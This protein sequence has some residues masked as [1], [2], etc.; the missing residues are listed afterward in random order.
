MSLQ[1]KILIKFPFYFTSLSDV[2]LDQAI[3][4]Q[5]ASNH[6]AVQIEQCECRTIHNGSSCQDPG[7]GYYRLRP[8]S[9]DDI[10]QFEQF[11]G[12]V[13][14]CD[15][16]GR[17]DICDKET[18]Q[19]LNC[20]NNTG[21]DRCNECAEG[22]YG[23]PNVNGCVPC[24][25]PETRKNFAKGCFMIGNE[26]NCLCKPGYTG[27]KC[28]FCSDGFYGNP[29][30][31]DGKCDPCDCNDDG[32]IAKDCDKKTGQCR[33]QMGVSG[34]K[35]DRCDEKKHILQNSRC[36][37]CD[38]CSLDLLNRLD[39][40]S[41]EGESSIAFINS[42][43]IIAPW[44]TLDNYTQELK[45]LEKFNYENH[46]IH[47]EIYG[48]D[49]VALEKF[50]SKAENLNSKMK[51]LIATKIEKRKLD[52]E[53][54]LTDALNT[55]NDIIAMKNEINGTIQH[56]NEYGSHISHMSVQNALKEAQKYAKEIQEH[57]SNLVKQK[58]NLLNA[59]M[60]IDDI[61]ENVDDLK[62]RQSNQS[63]QL[64]TQLKSLDDVKS[65]LSDIQTHLDT[66]KFQTKS[67]QELNAINEQKLNHLT[68]E[69]QKIHQL[70]LEINDHINT[71]LN[72]K[73]NQL[74]DEIESDLQFDDYIIDLKTL[75]GTVSEKLANDY[76]DIEKLK[77]GICD[78]AE[79]W[80]DKLIERS[81]KYSNKFRKTQIGAEEALRAGTAH[82][83]IE[84]A[85]K[86]AEKAA[87]EAKNSSEMS[88][89]ELNPLNK[90]SVIKRGEKSRE[91]SEEIIRLAVGDNES[92][93]GNSFI[94]F[95]KN[96]IVCHV[97]CRILKN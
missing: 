88:Y 19:C 93:K 56:L 27:K 20:Q 15:C 83:N 4:V 21:G 25:C 46:K 10:S 97:T 29:E 72:T 69:I 5:G 91:D 82:E 64:N 6:H 24:P 78:D 39:E 41:D 53:K 13:V 12:L 80:S 76:R 84:K 74:L 75:S 52:I 77:A 67:A 7:N 51:K 16:S 2:S 37:I 90:I 47:D 71:T 48:W 86:L 18:G 81:V 42:I 54:L 11:I 92:I 95:E 87:F 65:K 8:P 63:I 59:K 17:S 44:S 22:F 36:E 9:P 94:F 45:K 49:D 28:E 34:L 89:L 23:N 43:K 3:Y 30:F 50:E 85:I 38:V 62:Y 35:C 70:R 73:S 31:D 14:P 68:R 79:Q 40:I 55:L 32:S 1:R 26:V 57:E 96:F 61:Q 58:N 66:I 60:C 33:C